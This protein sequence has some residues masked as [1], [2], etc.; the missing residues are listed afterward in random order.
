VITKEQAAE[1][2]RLYHAEKWKVGTIARQLSIH[3]ATVGR[4]IVRAGGSAP[5]RRASISIAEPYVGLIVE[6][7]SK[8]PK[9]TASRLYVMAKERGYPG[10]PDHFRRVVSEHR[11]IE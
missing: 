5:S 2:L 4:L 10:G 8:Y 9:L 1:V 3:H 7:L 11:P 6:T